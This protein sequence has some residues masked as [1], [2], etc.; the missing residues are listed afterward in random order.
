MIDEMRELLNQE[1][2]ITKLETAI[3]LLAYL[4][5][6]VVFVVTVLGPGTLAP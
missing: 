1:S 6:A 2:G 4:I 3:V 5:V